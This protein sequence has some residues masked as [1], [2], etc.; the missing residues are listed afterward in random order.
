MQAFG[1]LLTRPPLCVDLLVRRVGSDDVTQQD[2]M[3]VLW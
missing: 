3:G 2:G 1:F